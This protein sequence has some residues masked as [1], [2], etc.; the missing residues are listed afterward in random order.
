[1]LC[2]EEGY[3]KMPGEVAAREVRHNKESVHVSTIV[4]LRAKNMLLPIGYFNQLNCLPLL[5]SG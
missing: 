5:Q 2:T 3:G 1:M 4:E